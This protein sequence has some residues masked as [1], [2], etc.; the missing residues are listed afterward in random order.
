[1]KRV[2]QG[3]INLFYDIEPLVIE[4]EVVEFYD[5]VATMEGDVASSRVCGVDIV[6]DKLKLGEILRIPSIGLA[7]YV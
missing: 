4:T 2:S 1:M 6:F 5:N 3:W 7:K